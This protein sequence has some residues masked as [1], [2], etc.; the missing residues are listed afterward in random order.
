MLIEVF[1]SHLGRIGMLSQNQGEADEGSWEVRILKDETIPQSQDQ[2]SDT[3]F[4]LMS[5]TQDYFLVLGSSGCHLAHAI[6]P[7]PLL[8]F[9]WGWG[10]RSCLLTEASFVV[11]LYPRQPF[12]ETGITGLL[13]PGTSLNYFVS[14]SP[15]TVC[16]TFV[17]TSSPSCCLLPAIWPLD[18]WAR[19]LR[20]QVDFTHELRALPPSSFYGYQCSPP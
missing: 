4:Y 12:E 18:L 9:L 17:P 14:P 1:K 15:T 3:E 6:S 19:F 7:A 20:K 2:L 16:Y 11:T 8:L 13:P 10:I 5:H